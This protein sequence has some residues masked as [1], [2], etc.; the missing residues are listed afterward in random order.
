MKK[1]VYSIFAILISVSICFSQSED[2][3]QRVKDD[4]IKTIFGKNRSNDVQE[5]MANK[6]Y[7]AA[8]FLVNLFFKVQNDDHLLD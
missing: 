8:R 7:R 4:E 2:K 6:T 5:G 3:K 1:L